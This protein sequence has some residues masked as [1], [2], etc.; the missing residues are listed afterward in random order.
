MVAVCPKHVKEGLDVLEVPHVYKIDERKEKQKKTC[1]C[2][3]CHLKADYKLENFSAY[4][5]SK[6]VKD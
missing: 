3:Y 2:Q 4:P 6:Q 1:K 5:P